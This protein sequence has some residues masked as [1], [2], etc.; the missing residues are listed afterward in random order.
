MK[1][2]LINGRT[3]RPQSVCV[4]CREPI[5]ADYPREIGTRLCYCDDECYA[6][7]RERSVLAIEN[8]A[9]AS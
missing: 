7:H 2:I 5:G 4:F 6:S 9:R 1:F 8:H 3:P